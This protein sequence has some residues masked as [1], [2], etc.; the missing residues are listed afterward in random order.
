[1]LAAAAVALEAVVM[2]LRGDTL[3]GTGDAA[4]DV[5]LCA[6]L[7]LVIALEVR[8]RLVPHG[9]HPLGRR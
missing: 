2:R 4:Q 1:M 8:L 9:N 7:L 6:G 5:L 3:R